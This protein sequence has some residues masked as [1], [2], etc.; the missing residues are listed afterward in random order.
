MIS[1][2]HLSVR[3]GELLALNDL[4]L[5]LDRGGVFGYIGPNGAGKSTLLAMLCG[6]VLPSAGNAYLA[7]RRRRMIT[8]MMLIM[9]MMTKATLT[10]KM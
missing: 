5:E 6:E 9:K 7:G 8:T 3:Y 4:S 1:I 2:S 10:I